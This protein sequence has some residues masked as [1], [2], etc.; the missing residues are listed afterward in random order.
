MLPGMRACPSCDR[1]EGTRWLQS[2]HAAEPTDPRFA[3]PR[4]PRH[5]S[6]IVPAVLVGAWV[7]VAALAWLVSHLADPAAWLLC[8]GLAL[9]VLLASAGFGLAWWRD[10]RRLGAADRLGRARWRAARYCARCDVVYA[11]G[12]PATPAGRLGWWDWARGRH[13][14]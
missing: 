7:T 5:Y 8:A 4:V 3:P 9:L 6:S 14:D 10:A 1:V 13:E 2:L 12:L 11:D